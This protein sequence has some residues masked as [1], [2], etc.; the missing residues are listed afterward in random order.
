[1]AAS[2]YT[3]DYSRTGK[4]E[5]DKSSSLIGKAAEAAGRVVGTVEETAKAAGDKAASMAG[6]A[7]ETT[8][9]IV[10]VVEK[11]APS[12]REAR[13]GVSEVGSTMYSAVRKSAK[14]QPMSTL[15]V[16][17]AIGFVIGAIWKS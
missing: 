1:M 5:T 15:F 7:A 17:G 9:R 16:A 4:P 2:T 6:K 10:G 8:G 11:V 14:K 13:D 3:G 12:L